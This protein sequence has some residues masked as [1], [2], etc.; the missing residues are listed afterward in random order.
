MLSG[1]FAP[2][3]QRGGA[4]PALP[5]LQELAHS[6]GL[7]VACLGSEVQTGGQ[8]SS[9][10]RAICHQKPLTRHCE[11]AQPRKQSRVYGAALDCFATLAM[12]V[13]IACWN[14]SSANQCFPL[15]M[16]SVH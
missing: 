15:T 10:L 7:Y 16:I 4:G 13:R 2:N 1:G 8:I 11:E 5:R 9:R 14:Y 6:A 3:G 12:T